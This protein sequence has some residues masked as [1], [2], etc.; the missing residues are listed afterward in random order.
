MKFLKIVALV[1]ILPLNA[2]GSEVLEHCLYDRDQDITACYAQVIEPDGSF[3][4]FVSAEVAEFYSFNAKFVEKLDWQVIADSELESLEP[5]LGTIVYPYSHNAMVAESQGMNLRIVGAGKP[6]L[7]W[8]APDSASKCAASVTGGA[9]GGALVGAYYGSQ[10]GAASGGPTGAA[11]G[12]AI[13]GT[14]GAIGGAS[15]GYATS[16]HCGCR[17][18]PSQKGQQSGGGGTPQTNEHP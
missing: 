8:C 7:V 15:T 12:T 1:L 16:D 9:A 18:R 10:A 6:M 13:G 3:E 11:A 17:P 14:L 4:N 2:H 5:T